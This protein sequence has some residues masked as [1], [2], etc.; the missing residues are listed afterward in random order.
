ML[1][2]F[3]GGRY[4]QPWLSDKTPWTKTMA[5]SLSRSSY[6]QLFSLGSG[7]RGSASERD[8][9]AITPERVRKDISR[10]IPLNLRHQVQQ[11]TGPIL[12]GFLPLKTP[13]RSPSNELYTNTASD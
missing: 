5:K 1:A 10:T 12:V 2:G 4:Q 7:R 11:R 9:I 8:S 13:H 6:Q 3:A